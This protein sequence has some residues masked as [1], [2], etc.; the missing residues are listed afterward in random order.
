MLESLKDAVTLNEKL[1]YLRTN[2]FVM[3]DIETISRARISLMN[4]NTDVLRASTK[5][6]KALKDM[7][8]NNK[9]FSFLQKEEA[10]P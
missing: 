8:S 3:K 9:Q 4:R 5:L 6:R 1:M 2:E 10:P 7:Y